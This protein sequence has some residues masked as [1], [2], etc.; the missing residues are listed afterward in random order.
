MA[1]KTPVDMLSAVDLFTVLTKKEVKK[2]HDAGKEVTFHAGRTI[3]SEGESAVGFHLILQGKANVT[4]NGILRAT[5]GPGDYF[6]EM[7]I[8]DRGP[9]SATVTA[10]TEV[11]TLG[12]ASWDFMPS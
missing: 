11:Q 12:I 3:V 6:G 9:R 10:E 7:A 4:V 8:I 2:I 1:A 5:L